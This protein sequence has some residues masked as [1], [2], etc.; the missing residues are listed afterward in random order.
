MEEEFTSK[1][2]VLEENKITIVQPTEALL[3]GMKDFGKTMAEEWEKA[4]GDDGKALLEA[5]RK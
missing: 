3:N 5:Y 1:V 2:K 4:A